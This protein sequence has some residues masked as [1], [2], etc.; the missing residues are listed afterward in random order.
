[1]I[2]AYELVLQR[3]TLSNEFHNFKTA[4]GTHMGASL[5]Q[6]RTSLRDRVGVWTGAALDEPI[7]DLCS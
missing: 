2:R 6:Y 5:G 3:Y 1:M 7:E 4:N